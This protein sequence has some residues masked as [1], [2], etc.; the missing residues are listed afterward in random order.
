MTPNFVKCATCNIVVNEVLAFVYNKI[1]I[2]DEETLIRVCETGFSAED[3]CD[4]KKLLFE[5]VPLEKIKMRKK[6]DKSR[7]NIQDII[8]LLKHAD[9][10]NPDML[11]MFVAR[12]LHKLPPITFDHLDATRLLRDILKLQ[13]SMLLL[14]NDMETIKQECNNVRQDMNEFCVAN[15]GQQS[16][17]CEGSIDILKTNVNT[18]RGVFNNIQRRFEYDS[19]PMGLDTTSLFYKINTDKS[20]ESMNSATVN[21]KRNPSPLHSRSI[22]D[23]SDDCNKSY[24]SPS[25]TRSPSEERQSAVF[26][27]HTHTN[28]AGEHVEAPQIT[29]VSTQVQQTQ[30]A[31]R[32]TVVSNTNNLMNHSYAARL[33]TANGSSPLSPSLRRDTENHN[34]RN[35]VTE[36][37]SSSTI[38]PQ[39]LKID[40]KAEEGKWSVVV[41]KK[42]SRYRN[43]FVSNHGKA[44]YG[45]ESKF[46]AA[47]VKV[48]L[49]ISNISK[50]TSQQDIIDYIV[51]KTQ[52]LV[53]LEKI[54]PKVDKGYDSYIFYVDS[55][56]VPLFLNDEIWPEGICFRKFIVFKKD[57]SNRK[58]LN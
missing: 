46:K 32:P 23:Q 30:R 44:S 41:N 9:A 21:N 17:Q 4:A 19:G 47:S 49:Y 18:K 26:V 36:S 1:G 7:K 48:P 52:V 13:D 33:I 38:V 2:M 50:D 24:I 5:A 29:A 56:K 35:V 54:A 42:K 58:E 11:P 12:E 22:G 51:R 43:R 14:Q 57:S 10:A 55:Y 8:C 28:S 39:V 16:P 6:N 31:V 3:I 34:N 45:P 40:K 15:R 27:A 37:Y 20:K 53:T 25:N